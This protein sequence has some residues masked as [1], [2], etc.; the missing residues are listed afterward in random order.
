MHF[1]DHVFPLQYPFYKPRISD[2]GRGWLL[3]ALLRTKPLYHVALALSLY[4][5]RGISDGDT[6][7]MDIDLAV[8]QEKHLEIC[9]N[10]FTQLTG[11][12]C[13]TNPMDIMLAVLQLLLFEVFIPHQCDYNLTLTSHEAFYR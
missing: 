10:A 4:H 7:V 5:R 12:S 6:N 13:P 2:G 1:L 3:A 8:Q 11:H 9:I